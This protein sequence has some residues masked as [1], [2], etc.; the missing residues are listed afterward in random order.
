MGDR[1]RAG[2]ATPTRL[3]PVVLAAAALVA[4]APVTAGAATDVAS[5]DALSTRTAEASAVVASALRR[6]ES[7]R[8]YRID[9]VQENY[10][11]LADTTSVVAGTLTYERP[12]R[13]SLAYADGSRIVVAD[14]S[15]RVYAAPTAQFFAV[16]VD[17]SDVAIDPP[18]LLRAYAPDP[19]RPFAAGEPLQDGSRVVNLRPQASF[20]E[21]ERVEVTIDPST[22]TVTRIAALSSSGDRTTYSLRASRFGVDVSDDEFILR[23][24]ANTTLIKGSPF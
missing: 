1:P 18:R 4:V 23:R 10:W 3:L 17:S 20:G 2:R 13:L 8:T 7:S 12:G 6:Y 19:A 14:D 24:P 16:E 21:P 15:M 9:F 22:G 11:A 5:S